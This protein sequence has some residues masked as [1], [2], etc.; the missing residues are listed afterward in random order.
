MKWYWSAAMVTGLS[1]LIVACDGDDDSGALRAQVASLQTQV[2]Q[3]AHTPTPTPPPDTREFCRAVAE[4]MDSRRATVTRLNELQALRDTLTSF[5]PADNDELRVLMDKERAVMVPRPPEGAAANLARINNLVFAL[6]AADDRLL[7]AIAPDDALAFN[8]A[9][10]E[11][12][13]LNQELIQL[14]TAECS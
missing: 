11:I 8:S 1:F 5:T 13:A 9:R 10:T 4:F 12:L 14:H 2:D 6:K 7:S 3:S